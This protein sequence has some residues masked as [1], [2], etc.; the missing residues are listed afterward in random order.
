MN[1]IRE[2]FGVD[3]VVLP[4]VHP[5]GL[6][7]AL[8]SV[9]VAHA[10]GAKGVFTINQGMNDSEVLALVREI[11]RRYPALWVGVNLLG[12]SPTAALRAALDACERIDGLWSDNALV[13]ERAADQPAAAE[14]VA[15]RRT[16]AWT[17]LYFGGV[18]FKYQREV[19]A[20]AIGPAAVLAMSYM[21]VVCTSGPGTGKAADVHKVIAMRQ[22]I[23]SEGA[24]ALA[25]GVTPDNIGAY[26]PYVDAFLVGT[27][28]EERFG[29]LD[30]GKVAA[31]LAAAAG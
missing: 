2:V 25:S 4:V 7:E 16:R 17:G 14:F 6:A 11:Q 9:E 21:D 5:I 29:V 8:A 26:L 1:R 30:R 10:A 15:T 3:R 13:D 27:G 28:I 24:I 19:A 18:A 20:D 12:H 31:L 22:A 23:G